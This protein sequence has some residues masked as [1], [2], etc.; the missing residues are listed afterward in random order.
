MICKLEKEVIL[1]RQD[2]D[3]TLLNA[4]TG[5]SFTLNRT[6]A[7]I[8]ELL[9]AELDSEK[10]VSSVLEEF[11]VGEDALR[12]DFHAFLEQLKEVELISYE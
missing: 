10:I 12:S 1:S 5:R 4:K 7:R 9:Q 3:V 2:D 8:W 11:D 6:G